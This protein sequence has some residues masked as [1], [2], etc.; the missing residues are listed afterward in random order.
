MPPGH[1]ENENLIAA[2]SISYLQQGHKRENGRRARSQ[3]VLFREEY[4]SCYVRTRYPG[5]QDDSRAAMTCSRKGARH[6]LHT[7]QYVARRN[8]AGR[9][10]FRVDRSRVWGAA[11]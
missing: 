5:R 1:E 4:E 2:I 3:F 6:E 11:N 10:L 8:L 9:Q 7:G